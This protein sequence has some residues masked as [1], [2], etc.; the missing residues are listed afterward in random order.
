MW[1]DINE[2][3]V[4]AQQIAAEPKILHGR[5]ELLRLF[6]RIRNDV[7]SACPVVGSETLAALVAAFAGSASLMVTSV[8]GRSHAFARMEYGAG[9]FVDVDIAGEEIGEESVRVEPAGRMFPDALPVE[10]S[11]ID[12]AILLTATE[13]AQ[14]CGYTATARA[15]RRAN[16]RSSYLLS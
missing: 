1:S 10:L 6:S 2:F 12:A 15:L 11:C 3:P 4:L 13:V 7:F 9:E 5:L 16:Q 14:A 8:L